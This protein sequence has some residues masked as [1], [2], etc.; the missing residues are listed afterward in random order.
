VQAA[1]VVGGAQD[2]NID[3]VLGDNVGNVSAFDIK[4]LY[5]D[6]KLTPGAAGSGGLDGNPDFNDA[7]LG[8]GWNCGQAGS[9]SPDVDAATGALHGVAFLSCYATGAGATVA[10]ATAIATLRLHAAAATDTGIELSEVHITHSDATELGSCNPIV[11]VEMTCAGG[12]LS[13]Q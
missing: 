6:T 10:S 5:D 2:V 9:P 4:I 12:V 8:T 13:S 11:L 7:A 1:R 3:V